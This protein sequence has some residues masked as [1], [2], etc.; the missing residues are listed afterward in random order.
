MVS[1]ASFF[2]KVVSVSS[3]ISLYQYNS[4]IFIVLCI[5]SLLF[6]STANILPT[7]KQVSR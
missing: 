1:T 7:L 6:L 4:F 5:T 3:F 2:D